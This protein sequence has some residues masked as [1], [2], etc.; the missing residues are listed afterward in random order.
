MTPDI[1][2]LHQELASIRSGLPRPLSALWLMLC[3]AAAIAV[4]VIGA[5]T[6]ET[7]TLV[8]PDGVS[9]LKFGD[10]V[11]AINRVAD[12]LT[13]VLNPRLQK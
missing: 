8:S 10:P 13:D 4:G 3:V 1:A 2:N 7:P 9:S 5:V 11:T 6:V 12:Q